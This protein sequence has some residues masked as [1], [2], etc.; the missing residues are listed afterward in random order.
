MSLLPRAH[1]PAPA[2][3]LP[4][5]VFLGTSAAQAQT[6]SRI[7]DHHPE[8]SPETRR[9]DFEVALRLAAQKGPLVSLAIAGQS[10]QS[11]AQ[12][13]AS[14]LVAQ[15]PL[16]Q[17]QLGPR[18]SQGSTSPE[19]IIGVVQPLSVVPV[20]SAQKALIKT[21]IAARAVSIEAARIRSAEQAGHAWLNQALAHAQME[22]RSSQLESARTLLELARA[23]ERSGE[24]DPSEVALLSAEVAFLRGTVLEAEG[25]HFQ[26]ASDLAWISGEDPTR[27]FEVTGSLE[28]VLREPLDRSLE[29]K[30][31]PE[32][33]VAREQ[34]KVAEG[35]VGVARAQNAA[36]FSVGV[37]YQREGTGDQILTGVFS[38]PLPIVRQGRHQAE[39]AMVRR[40]DARGEI[41]YAETHSSLVLRKAEHEVSHA[42]GAYEL[43]ATEA[44]PAQREALHVLETQYR[45]GILTLSVLL[46]G[47]QRLL[48][49]EE[50]TLSALADWKHAQLHYL[51]QAGLLLEAAS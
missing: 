31:A 44:V 3:V 5:V 50:R 27:P 34:A 17:G 36:G 48:Q 6:T 43:L 32:V 20:G 14:P 37:Q 40:E 47:R 41:K 29:P 46:V 9:L 16:V 24:V 42:R 1:R 19:V 2:W 38:L 33:R 35:E 45:E 7:H 23:R 49:T 18:W 21:E 39:R 10:A 11:R 25:L 15:A 26:A 22:V 12:D 28:S 4:L 8:E 51:A 30:A 13:S